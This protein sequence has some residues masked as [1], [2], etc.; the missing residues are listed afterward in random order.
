MMMTVQ[1]K[2]PFR[3]RYRNQPGAT[4]KH[5]V[6]SQL[7]IVGAAAPTI[8]NLVKAEDNPVGAAN[9]EQ[10]NIGS[11]VNGIFLNVQVAATGTAALANIYFFVAG[12]P[13]GLV[14]N[15][16]YPNGNVVGTSD[17]R[18]M[19][20]HQEMIMTEK[21]TTAISR[22]MFRGVIGIPKKFRRLGIR[23]KIIISFFTPGVNFDVCFQA[24]YI[25][26]K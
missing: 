7:G 1:A 17:L 4:F 10:V 25:E 9:P 3:Q 22:T 21:N 18:K 15:A 8:V 23:D 14:P 5:V 12:N 16:S 11:H 2:M 26:R 19:V 6:D 20:F 13:G 24:I